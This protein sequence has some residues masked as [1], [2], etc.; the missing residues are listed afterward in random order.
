MQAAHYLQFSLFFSAYRNALANQT[1]LWKLEAG[2]THFFS[3]LKKTKRHAN[4]N[5]FIAP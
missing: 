3:F 5:T 4:A 1:K 2:L